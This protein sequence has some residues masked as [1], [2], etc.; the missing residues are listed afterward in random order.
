MTQLFQQGYLIA[1][2]EYWDLTPE[3]KDQIVNG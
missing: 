3:E 1:P 2:Q